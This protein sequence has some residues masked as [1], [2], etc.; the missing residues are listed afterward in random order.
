MI[1]QKL[2]SLIKGALMKD[3]SKIFY[4]KIFSKDDLVFDLGAN[5]GNRTSVFL[6]IGAKVIAVEP[7]PKL[8]KILKKK[9]KKTIIVDKAIGAEKG[10]VTLY[11]NE[12]TVLSTTSKEWIEVAKES[13]K[14][15][16]LAS[17]FN[18]EVEVEQITIKELLKEYGVPKFIK[19]DTEGTELGIIRQLDNNEIGCISFEFHEFKMEEPKRKS[20]EIIK[21]LNSIGYD[22][23]NI[24]FGESMLFAGLDSFSYEELDKLIDALPISWGDI[25]AFNNK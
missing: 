6:D 5:V 13:N 7:N 12:S 14:F 20:K 10:K 15:G 18:D 8:V 23:F 16:E 19:I 17:K 4:S 3:T 21:H 24:S 22:S 1:T 2:K 25:Y 11:L 9:F